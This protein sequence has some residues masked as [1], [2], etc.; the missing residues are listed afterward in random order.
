M[1]SPQPTDQKPCIDPV[2]ALRVLVADLRALA[3]RLALKEHDRSLQQTL[4]A[5]QER[6]SGPRAVVLLLG[7]HED[8]KRRFLERLLGPNLTQVPKPTTVC[9]RLE[10][11]AQLECSLTMPQGLTAV[12]PPDQLEALEKTVRTIRLPNPTLKGDLAV[13]D[14]PVVES[15]EP[16]ASLLECAAQADA[17]IFVLQADHELSEASYALLSRLP[18]ASHGGSCTAD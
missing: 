9:T 5:A 18:G 7:E 17:W 2:E 4:K 15:M 14:T 8:L 3:D 1:T 11:G 12:L 13:I 10:Y 16:A 6:V